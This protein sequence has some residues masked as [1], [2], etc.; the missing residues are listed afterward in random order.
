MKGPSLWMRLRLLLCS[1]FDFHG[2]I[3]QIEWEPN[4]LPIGECRF[5]GQRGYMDVDG[6][7]FYGG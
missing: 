5:C 2:P 6:Q 1:W 7:L 4:Q 3:D